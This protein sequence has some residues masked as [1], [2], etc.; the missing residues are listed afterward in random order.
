MKHKTF[1]EYE[2]E[3]THACESALGMLLR[4]FG[5]LAPTLR[6]VGGL[7]PRYLTPE[8][9]PDV[10]KHAG[11]TDVDIVLA[12]EVLAEKGKY[13]KLSEQ[14]KANGFSRVVNKD[15]NVSSWRWERKV[16]GQNIVVEF[17]QHTDDPA[18][19]ARAESVVDEGVSAMQILHAGVVHELYL[20]RE[21][22]VQLPDGNGKA[23]VAIRYA[24]AIAFILLKALAFDDR[25]TNKD[26][27]DL[28]HV[29]RHAGSI[30]NLAA[31]YAQRVKEGKHHDALEQGLQ[32]LERKFCD[33]KDIEGFEKEG[34]AQFCAFHEI[35][36][37]GSDERLLE[38]RNVSGLV[39]EFVTLVRAHAKA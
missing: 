32:A 22:V 4:A 36:E 2:D 15:G 5:T 3:L 30:E 38:Q 26:A 8:A 21:V 18:K 20:E 6:L 29:M 16:D 34:P 27:A 31:L 39:T 11:T 7:V 17:L 33:D 35:G 37:Q 1:A 28:I 14:L 9:P 10:P 12:I 25:K 23:K 24:D 13:N 19:N